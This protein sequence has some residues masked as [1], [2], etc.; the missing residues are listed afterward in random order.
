MRKQT[1]LVFALL[2]SSASSFFTLPRLIICQARRLV[3]TSAKKTATT[4]ISKGFG[5]LKTKPVEWDG[6]PLEDD[7]TVSF[8]KYLRENGAD[9]SKVCLASF[10][11][12]RGVMALTDIRP[13]EAIMAIPYEL[14]LDLGPGTDDPTLPALVFHGNFKESNSKSRPYL[15][16]IPTVDSGD[17]TT[18]DFFTAQE[19]DLLQCPPIV[20]ET[21]VRET[22]LQGRFEEATLR[23]RLEKAVARGSGEPGVVPTLEELRWATWVVVS[24]VL[25]VLSDPKQETNCLI[26]LIDMV[27]HD[28]VKGPPQVLSGRAAPGGFMKVLAGSQGIKAGEQV[29]VCV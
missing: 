11:G 13:G 18:T 9:C 22:R 2:V 27:N 26:P 15:N 4:N 25:T 1:P 24:R 5:A 29:R 8:F 3:A 20:A 12:L 19:L 6:V 10:G 14:C 28:P 16:K 23:A 17:C 7:E 21:K